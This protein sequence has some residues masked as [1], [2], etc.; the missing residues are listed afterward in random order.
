[1]SKTQDQDIWKNQD[2]Q[3]EQDKQQDPVNLQDQVTCAQD[4]MMYYYI[5]LLGWRIIMASLPCSTVTIKLIINT[6]NQQKQTLPVYQH[7]SSS[8]FFLQNGIDHCHV[9]A[10]VMQSLL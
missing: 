6:P 7:K 5:L 10:I 2:L 8:Y 1:M 4:S 3:Q 9:L